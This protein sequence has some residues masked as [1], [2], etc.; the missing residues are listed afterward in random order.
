MTS[1]NVPKKSTVSKKE[2]CKKREPF[3]WINQA[4]KDWLKAS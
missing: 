2:R 3:N 4:K 1:D